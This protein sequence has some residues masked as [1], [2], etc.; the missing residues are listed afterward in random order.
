MT[1]K[2]SKKIRLKIGD[3][4]E[5]PLPDGRYAYGRI[6]KDASVGIYRQISSESGNP[7]IGSRD[8]LFNVGMFD[9]DIKTGKF[10]IVGR[11]PFSDSESPWPPPQCVI[12]N[13]DNTYSLYH[14]GEITKASKE[15]CIGLEEAAVWDIEEHIIP[16]IMGLPHY[17]RIK[18]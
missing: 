14:M 18:T 7:P 16:R 17:S 9:D 10:Q 5:I 6:Y 4:F 2:E 3:V 12:N 1:K 11:D 8:F 13:Y 15:E